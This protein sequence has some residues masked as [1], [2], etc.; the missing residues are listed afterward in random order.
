MKHLKTY[1]IFESVYKPQILQTRIESIEDNISQVEEITQTIKDI[2]LPISDMGYNISVTD[3]TYN[4]GP[5]YK[6]PD[7]FTIRV[8]SY[9]DKPLEITDDIKDEFIRM[10]DYLESLGFNSF[11]ALCVTT[12]SQARVEF[13]KFINQISKDSY[14]FRNLLFVVKIIDP[15]K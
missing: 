5:L 1:N 7:E 9:V 8:V 6:S 10:V 3:N 11:E 12:G 13:S 2:L 14:I 4:S 15:S